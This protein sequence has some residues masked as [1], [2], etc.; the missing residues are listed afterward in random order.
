MHSILRGLDILVKNPAVFI[1][2][3]AP[4]LVHS[5]FIALA[6]IVFPVKYYA[7]NPYPY[8][9]YYEVTSPNPWLS[10][11]GYFLASI[12]GF[13]ANCVVVDMAND[14]VSGHSADLVKSVNLIASRI[15]ILL[16]VALVSAICYITIILIPVALFIVVVAVI[17]N[18]GVL[19]SLKGTM[20]FTVRNL[21]EVVVFAVIVIVA[22]IIF[23]LV[24]LIPSIGA[25]LGSIIAWVSSIVF[26]VASVQ[27]YLALR[28]PAPPASQQA[29][30][31]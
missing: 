6:Y 9:H 2:S 13:L 29:L 25:Y 21:N 7:F 8:P 23:N 12:I 16:L 27:L 11:T 15:G 17:E 19:E 1:P 4:L 30:I 10:G 20:E 31:S 5:L 24:S 22:S 18:K 28:Q 3:I 14:I 26:T